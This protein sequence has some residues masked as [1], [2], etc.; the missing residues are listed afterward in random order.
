MSLQRRTS[1]LVALGLVAGALVFSAQPAQAA[2]FTEG[3]DNVSNLA[4]WQQRNLSSPI[5]LNPNWVQGNTTVFPAHLGPADSYIAAN[6]NATS[7]A[8]TI[9][10]WLISPVQGDLTSTDE[11]SFWTRASP[12]DLYPDRLEVRLSTNGS[13][14]PGTSNTSVGDFTKVLTTVNPNQ[15]RSGYPTIWA[16]YTISLA[17]FVIGRDVASGCFAFRYHVTNGGPSGS[18]SD[19]IGIDTVSYVDNPRPPDTTPPVIDVTAGPSGRT[20]NATPTFAFSADEEATF[21]CRVSP[22]EDDPAPFDACSGPAGTHTIGNPLEDG[23]YTFEVRATDL[24]GNAATE[25][26]SFQVTAAACTTATAA[27]EDAELALSSAQA[28]HADAQDAVDA[29][30][31]TVAAAQSGFDDSSDDMVA[32]ASARADAED[33]AATAQS[34]A[35]DRAAAVTSASQ[36]KASADAALAAARTELEKTEATLATARTALATSQSGATQA[37]SSLTQTE[38]ALAEARTAMATA[39]TAA[40]RAARA[41]AAVATKVKDARKALARAKRGTSVDAIAKARKK[42]TALVEKNRAAKKAL[43][44]ARTDRR[45]AGAALKAAEAAHVTA[46]TGQ[47]DSETGRSAAE[48]KV[49]AAQAAANTARVAVT[50]AETEQ[51]SAAAALSDARAALAA[52]EAVLTEAQETLAEAEAAHAAA[53]EAHAAAASTLSGATDDLAAAQVVLDEAQDALSAAE[54]DLADAEDAV[55]GSCV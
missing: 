20:S 32:A 41:K 6:F 31:D 40:K 3:F 5:G 47:S 9:S 53:E 44:A 7:G 4:G 42:V 50:T 54:Q 10:S 27:V 22:A 1:G 24:A 26:R 28:S 45:A 11:L 16:K 29:A 23:D 15:V 2:S 17:D 36:A 48:Q 35:T 43:V 12:D 52:S 38:A 37:Q 39:Q 13:C 21:E 55:T 19:Y 18:N 49:A 25:S 34:D 33:A 14:D 51:G 46:G 8:N 30:E